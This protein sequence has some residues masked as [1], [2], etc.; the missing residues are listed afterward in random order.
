MESRFELHSHCTTNYCSRRAAQRAEVALGPSPIYKPFHAQEM[1]TDETPND[2]QAR[3][4]AVLRNQRNRLCQLVG[5]GIDMP[6]S[7]YR[8]GNESVYLSDVVLGISTHR[9]RYDAMLGIDSTV[10]PLWP[11]YIP[12]EP[13]KIKGQ[14]Y[15]KGL[16]VPPGDLLVMLDGRYQSLLADVGVQTGSAGTGSFAV[17]VDGKELF[18]SGP[19]TAQD[20]PKK[21]GVSLGG[22]QQMILRS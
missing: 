8:G 14:L 3:P 4:F 5:R 15:T 13:L 22:A 9:I 19:M 16:G 12:A 2:V 20:P 17:I 18:S 1:R 7:P 21:V 10:Y 11:A 6:A